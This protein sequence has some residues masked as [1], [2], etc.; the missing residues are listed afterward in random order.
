MPVHLG[1]RNQIAQKRRSG[2]QS[3]DFRSE[4]MNHLQCLL[5]T[6]HLQY[7]LEYTLETKYSLETV[8]KLE[9]ETASHFHL[10]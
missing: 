7:L 8:Y 4:E 1:K 5:E 6:D 9:T 2:W 10:S 3:I